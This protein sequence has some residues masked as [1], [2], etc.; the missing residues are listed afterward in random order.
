MLYNEA[1]DIA[2]CEY[3]GYWPF[4]RPS[5]YTL[6]RLILCGKSVEEVMKESGTK[7][8]KLSV[9][10]TFRSTCWLRNRNLC[11]RIGNYDLARLREHKHDLLYKWDSGAIYDGEQ[12]SGGGMERLQRPSPRA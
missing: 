9:L 8:K 7:W 6:M 1:N 10:D 12:W 2:G 5:D 4:V 3:S 11:A